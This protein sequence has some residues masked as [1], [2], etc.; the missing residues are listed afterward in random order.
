MA[1]KG[2]G[3]GNRTPGKAQANNN[4]SVVVYRPVQTNL[5]NTQRRTV[6]AW[7]RLNNKLSIAKTQTRYWKKYG[8]VASNFADLAPLC[9]EFHAVTI[10]SVGARA[11]VNLPNTGGFHACL[12]MDP[13]TEVVNPFPTRLDGDGRS[14]RRA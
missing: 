14:R 10:H 9:A 6:Q 8:F 2:K 3:K 1:K 11:V 13:H 12:A 5:G 7:M 4:R